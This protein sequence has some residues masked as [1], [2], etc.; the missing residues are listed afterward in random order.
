[1]PMRPRPEGMSTNEFRRR[2]KELVDWI[3][4]FYDRIEMLPVQSEV[5]PGELRAML[6]DA[7][8]QSPESFDALIADLDEIVVPGL[9]NWLRL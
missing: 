3:A 8:P 9:T 4:D 6:P 1:M 5:V 2:G 7:A